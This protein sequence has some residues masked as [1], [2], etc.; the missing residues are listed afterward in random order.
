M[1]GVDKLHRTFLK[2]HKTFFCNHPPHHIRK[3]YVFGALFLLLSLGSFFLLPT[4]ASAAATI[5]TSPTTVLTSGLVGY[6]TFDGNDTNW[7]TNTTGYN[8]DIV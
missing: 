5:G 6:S 7:G 3:S 8:Q 4:I 2:L 1:R